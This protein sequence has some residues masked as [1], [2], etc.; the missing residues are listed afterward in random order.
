[1]VIYIAKSLCGE[2]SFL[3]V[4]RFVAKQIFRKNTFAKLNLKILLSSI[5]WLVKQSFLVCFYDI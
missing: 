1:M 2:L 5:F 3:I 4:I